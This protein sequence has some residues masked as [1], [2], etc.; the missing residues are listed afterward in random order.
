[1][2][3][4]SPL[5]RSLCFVRLFR[6][7]ALLRLSRRRLNS[8]VEFGRDFD[9]PFFFP[10]SF[11]LHPFFPCVLFFF[12]GVSSGFVS[13]TPRRSGRTIVFSEHTNTA[14]RLSS[15]ARTSS[16]SGIQARKMARVWFAA[17]TALR[18]LCARSVSR[19]CA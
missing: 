8:L 19:R 2:W 6:L 4:V 7:A 15:R 5:A 12:V 9:S 11:F 17:L 16:F 18:F 14:G 3:A 1:L 10:F 13:S